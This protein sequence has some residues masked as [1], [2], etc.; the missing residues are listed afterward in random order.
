MKQYLLLILSLFTTFIYGQNTTISGSVIDANTGETLIGASIVYG[1]GMGISADYDGNFSFSVPNGDRKIT[2]SY[3]GYQQQS[4]SIKA[5]GNTVI[6]KFKLKPIQLSEV[7]IVGDVA[8]ERETPV[9][10]STIS[11]KKVNEELA[12]QD[13]PMIL[14]STPGVYATQSGGGDGDARITIRGF[15]QRNVA[16]MID[17]IPVNDM[18]NGW[19]YWS[20]WSGLDAVTSNIQVQRGLGASKIAIPSVGGTMNIIT[21]GIGNKQSG[22]IK[23][24][25]GSFG[26]L[27]TS[28]GYNS[29]KMD[30]GWGF[31][32]AGS[33]K[34]GNGFVEETWTEGYFYYAKIQK[35]IGN[36]TL[37]FS[38][39]GAPQK[40]GQR[41]YKSDIATYDTTFAQ[42]LG[43]TSS[44]E[45][46][47]INQGIDYNK[48]W[49][50]IDRWT[51][52]ENGDTIHNHSILNTK[53]NYFHKPQYS[54]RHFW[55]VNEKFY[56]SNILY[57]SIG[58][59]GGTGISGNTN[60]YDV[61]GQY[62]LQDA[63]NG[64][65]DSASSSGSYIDPL[66]SDT[67]FKASTYLRSSINNHYWYGILSTANYNPSEKIS[68]S[69]GLD[70]RTYKGEH[71][72]EVYDLLG[73]DY[74]I[75]ESNELQLTQVKNVGDIVGYHNDGF[76]KWIGGFGQVEYNN[77]KV[78]TFF[79]IS[80]SNS[81]YSRHD[82]FKKKDLVL[83]DT[84]FSEVLGTSVALLQDSIYISS[85]NPN[86]YHKTISVD[87]FEY[88]GQKYTMNSPEARSAIT[89]WKWIKGFTIKTGINYNIDELNNVFFNIGYISKAPRFNNV[90]D[91]NNQLFRDI[92]NEQVKAVEGGYS[93][94][95]RSLSA[96]LNAYH[97]S[98]INKPSNGG[99]IIEVDEVP[100]R[101]N[102]NGMNALHQGIEMDFAYKLSN[103]LTLEGLVSLGDWRWTSSDTV[104]FYDDDNNPVIDE[105]G[106]EVIATFNAERVHVG[107]AAQT[108]YGISLRYEPT[109]NSY[110]KV[111]GTH[112][113]D[114][115]SD[116]D[117]L[118]LN[119]ENAGR[120]SWK[121]PAYQL[122]DLHAGYKISITPKNKLDI[123]FSILNLLDKIYISDA[124]NND[125]YNANYQDFDAKSAGVFFGLGRRFNISA[126][127]NF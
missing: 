94:R 4:K 114:Y 126:K 73:G 74:A 95:S 84:T 56:V 89:D 30:N 100:Y 25:I 43:D 23:Q 61:F 98:W 65:V 18:E 45:G 112:F 64:N 20:N 9:A 11:L 92:Q 85:L 90:F 21:K 28:I 105:S 66:Y 110:L 51:L 107:D 53:Q 13:I 1:K 58:N 50:N 119:G 117:P 2:V 5:E 104:R 24:D 37:T 48:H 113:D 55:V 99:V 122:I 72:R 41:S 17:G 70:L 91:Y 40:H 42:S 121:I 47:I 111:R 123:K 124:Q 6:V 35:E 116:F 109:S 76:V 52:D 60:N 77:G 10:F 68:I 54:L 15:N 86:G 36:H 71:Y 75:D 39:M 31:T 115:Y 34:R 63:Y 33:Y 87:T 29:G 106:N 38:A 88:N 81:G 101:A 57:A 108:Q 118:S 49:G 97:T 8:K 14:N 102:I 12:S 44:F 79:N 19:V 67:D 16:V 32:L 7:H 127:I 22:T 78:S 125:P 69:G 62:N 83:S 120:E 93:Y 26:R 46:R 96:N 80:G 3:V 59:G 82:Y 27:K 103:K